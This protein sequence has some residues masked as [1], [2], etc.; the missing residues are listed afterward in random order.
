MNLFR[1]DILNS[2]M[3][4]VLAA[5]MLMLIGTTM[6]LNAYFSYRNAERFKSNLIQ[7]SQSL[8]RTLAKSS[9]LA[10]FT[11]NK[12]QLA[13]AA[14]FLFTEAE[15]QMIIF[16]DENG[17]VLQSF[18][19]KGYREN[20]EYLVDMIF[21]QRLHDHQSGASFV[22]EFGS[23]IVVAEPV[24]AEAQYTPDEIFADTLSNGGAARPTSL[25][26]YVAMVTDGSL[27]RNQIQTVFVR[28]TAIIVAITLLSCLFTLIVIHFVVAVPLRGLVGEIRRL[29]DDGGN[30]EIQGDSVIPSDFSEMITILRTSY[31][32]IYDLKNTLEEKVEGRTR[33]LAL[34]NQELIIQKNA[35]VN[36][37]EQFSQTLAQLQAVQAQLVQSE[38]MAALGMLIS[39]LSH[40]IKNSINFIA[41]SL[42]LLEMTIASALKDGGECPAAKLNLLLGNIREGVNRTVQ[43]ITDLATFC[44][45]GGNVFSPIDI[46]PGLKAAVAIV[47]REFSNRITFYE[48]HLRRLPM[49][50]G[51]SGQLNQV[52]LNILLNAAQS[53]SEKGEVTIR[54][55][56]ENDSV[57]ISIADTGQG[58]STQNI[59]R[60]FD[61]FF[62]TKDV[63]KGTGLGLSISYSTIKNHGGVILVTSTVGSGSTFEII[64]PVC[65]V[66]GA[67]RC[68]LTR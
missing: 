64:L 63:G 43:V 12:D 3:A 20:I 38:K 44:Y 67:E 13:A 2:F 45:D 21:A 32:T 51:L 49:V 48:E 18:K 19:G 23:S 47:R 6:A 9:R 29:S 4:R 17:T 22:K 30:G 68:F 66:G 42:P 61:P 5:I 60:I 33:Q 25:I 15:C 55:W 59:D 8:T 36:S 14:S 39:G 34:S 40:E 27:I 10:V 26:G 46:L 54:S 62:T 53:I 50:N 58:I 16:F 37:N 7:H 24:T 1:L 11:G 57:H 41:S 52:F 56:E 31:N 28:D 35:L 65:T